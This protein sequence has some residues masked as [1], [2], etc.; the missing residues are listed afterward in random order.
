MHK[1]VSVT[2]GLFPSLIFYHSKSQAYLEVAPNKH[3]LVWK[4]LPIPETN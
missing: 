1:T 4:F 3:L 2:P